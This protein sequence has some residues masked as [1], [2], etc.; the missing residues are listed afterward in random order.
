MIQSVCKEKA[1]E[2]G[3]LAMKKKAFIICCVLSLL[4]I[5]GCQES[6]ENQ[7]TES[8][9]DTGAS[10]E[11]KLQASRMEGSYGALEIYHDKE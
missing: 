11:Q 8:Q 2:E 4:V 9:K 7:S 3:E 5:S 10:S 6:S 1:L